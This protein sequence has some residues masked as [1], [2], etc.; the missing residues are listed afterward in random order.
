MHEQAVAESERAVSL[1]GRNPARL[2]GLARAY[3]ADGRKDAAEKVLAELAGR[4][5]HGYVSQYSFARI[6][7]ALGNADLA[8]AALNQAYVERDT[9]LV[10]LKVDDAFD[11]LRTNARFQDLLR[12]VGFPS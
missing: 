9:L 10:W 3:A 2:V 12:R 1:S 8:L 6:H 11:P 4:A 7:I 5:K